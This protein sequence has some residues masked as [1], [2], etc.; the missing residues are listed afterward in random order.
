[1]GRAK[2]VNYYNGKFRGSLT[3]NECKI[4]DVLRT[5]EVVP[6]LKHIIYNL[7]DSLVDEMIS[8]MRNYGVLPLIGEKPIGTLKD[9]QTVGVAYMYWAGSLILGDSVGLGKTVQA[10]GLINY[11]NNE[12]L[13]N[14][15]RPVR[16]LFLTNKNLVEQT[17]RELIKFTGEYVDSVMGEARYCT[18]FINNNP[19]GVD[20]SVIGT[21]SLLTQPLFTSWLM[22]CDVFPFDVIFVDESSVLGNSGQK[23]TQIVKSARLLFPY[24][25][26]VVLLNATPFETNLKTFVSQLNLLDS[27]FLPTLQSIQ[28]EYYI[29]DYRGMFPRPTGKYKN[30]DKFKQ[31][32]EYR[33]FARTRQSLGARMEDSDGK[34]IK[35]PLSEAQKRLLRHVSMWRMVCDCPNYF[36]NSFDDDS[37]VEF[38]EYNVPKLKALREL[39]EG[40]LVDVDSILLYI[41]YIEAQNSVVEWLENRGIS[42]GVLNGDTKNAVRDDIIRKFKSKEYRVLVT[43]VQRGLNFGS[44]DYCI[45]YSFDPSPQ[46]MAQMEGRITRSFDVIGKHV[47]LLCSEGREY[48]YLVEKIME[49][50]KSSTEFTEVDSSCIMQLLLKED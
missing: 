25:S 50:A 20:F 12:Y 14:F 13:N 9:Y 28:K 47:Y 29:Y 17:R 1:M 26:R 5:V 11:L 40:D 15:G 10:S 30:A 42:V 31:L 32:V 33:Y 3:E 23:V 6:D 27:E 34:L 43:N 2:V 36:N 41:P 18:K 38:D 7:D 45:F 49:R 44:C 37:Y 24:F 16:F 46:R 39:M 22:G 35:V 19:N 21:H 8:S 4:L 48:D